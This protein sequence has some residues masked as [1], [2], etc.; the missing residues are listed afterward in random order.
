MILINLH[1]IPDMFP[2]IELLTVG[3]QFA[4]V[5]QAVEHTGGQGEGEGG[6]QQ[7]V[8]SLLPELRGRFISFSSL[9]QWT[10]WT[11]PFHTVFNG[12]FDLQ[13]P[14]ATIL[15]VPS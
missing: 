9:I 14:I 7:P 13:T 3:R 4:E 2:F 6:H 1:M 12:P 15:L 11:P 5:V 8:D 10:R